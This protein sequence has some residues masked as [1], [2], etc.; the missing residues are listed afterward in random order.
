MKQFVPSEEG[1]VEDSDVE[2]GLTNIEPQ[3]FGR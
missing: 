2:D 1:P 3:L